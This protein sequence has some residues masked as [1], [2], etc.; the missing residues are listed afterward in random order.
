MTNLKSAACDNNYI[1]ANIQNC[2]SALHSQESG[3]FKLIEIN[4]CLVDDILQIAL[5]LLRKK[6]LTTWQ[7][8]GKGERYTP[9]SEKGMF[10]YKFEDIQKKK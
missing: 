1:L 7:K 6:L 2:K 10:Y 5:V 3:P 8:F 4:V 9:T